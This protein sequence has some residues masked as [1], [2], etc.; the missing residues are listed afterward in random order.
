MAF[1]PAR[2]AGYSANF[3]ITYVMKTIQTVIE[4]TSEQRAILNENIVLMAKAQNFSVSSCYEH[5]ETNTFRMHHINYPILRERFGLPA[6]LA[7]VANKY[8]C[9]A[10]K[11]TLRKKM[12]RQPKF[13]G[14]FI[15]YDKRSSTINLVKGT[16]SLLTKEGRIKFTFFIPKYFRKYTDWDVKESNLVKCRD[17]RFRLMISIEKPTIISSKKGNVLGIDRGINN[18]I[19]TSDGWLYDSS[20]VFSIKKKYAGLGSRLQSKGTHSAS[21]H[22]NKVRGREQRFMRDVNHVISRRLVDSVGKDGVIA[23]EKLNGIR[24]ARHR[25]KQNWL[26]SNWAF[27]QLEQFLTYKG[28]EIGVAVE[29]VR[30]K[31]TSRTCSICGHCDKSQRQGSAFVCKACGVVLH[32]DLNASVNILHKYTLAG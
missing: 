21:R 15:H 8:A 18:L 12:S 1:I 9:A 16:A 25:R 32:A 5:N 6:Q 4:E 7:V 24:E 27:Y 11:T 31:D 3:T 29:F 23:L 30:A 28:E 22:L 19:A 10:V 20:H 17:G 26:F 2:R 14:T 13:S